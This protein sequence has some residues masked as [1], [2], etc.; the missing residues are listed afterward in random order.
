MLALKLYIFHMC[1]E[2]KYSFSQG[3]TT[4]SVAQIQTVKEKVAFSASTS[5]ENLCCFSDDMFITEF[6]E[7]NVKKKVSLE[8][9]Y[10]RIY[11]VLNFKA[12]R[13]NLWRY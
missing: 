1:S 4:K 6:A 10:K 8:N 11:L 9:K 5:M 7:V 12:V 3:E 2:S 13:H